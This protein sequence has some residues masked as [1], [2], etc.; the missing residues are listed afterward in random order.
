MATIK[1]MRISHGNWK[2]LRRIGLQYML[3]YDT[4]E[5]MSLDDAL[6]IVLTEYEKKHSESKKKISEENK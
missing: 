1:L 5:M 6:T 4:S 2:R 3:N